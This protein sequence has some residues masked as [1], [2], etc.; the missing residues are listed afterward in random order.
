MSMRKQKRYLRGERR[1]KKMSAKNQLVTH[2]VPPCANGHLWLLNVFLVEKKR[3]H[4]SQENSQ[5]L[6]CLATSCRRRSCCR[7]NFSAQPRVQGNEERGLGLCAS[8]CT[9]RVYWL[10]KRRSQPM[11]KHGKRRRWSVWVRK[12]GDESREGKGLM[13]TGSRL[14]HDG[15]GEEEFEESPGEGVGREWWEEH[16]DVVGNSDVVNSKSNAFT[17]SWN[18]GWGDIDRALRSERG[19]YETIDVAEPES[20][21][22]ENEGS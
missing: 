20:A 17:Y 3:P 11:I 2:R 19:E 14:E 15:V 21:R 13:S 6:P 4:S 9:L 8:M 10:V 5:I 7:E 16:M 22:K 12:G 18:L 1:E